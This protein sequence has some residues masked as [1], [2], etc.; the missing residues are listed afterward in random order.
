MIYGL[1]FSITIKAA[2]LLRIFPSKFLGSWERLYGRS[3]EFQSGRSVNGC[4]DPPD[5]PAGSEMREELW[6]RSAQ[7]DPGFQCFSWIEASVSF[8]SL[9]SLN[10]KQFYICVIPDGRIHIPEEKQTLIFLCTAQDSIP[11]PLL[12]HYRQQIWDYWGLNYTWNSTLQCFHSQFS[13]FCFTNTAIDVIIWAR[14][15]DGGVLNPFLSV[16][17]SA[18]VSSP[19]ER[20]SINISIK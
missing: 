15:P 20:N 13:S 3:S 11:S 10:F 16:K 7:Q 4:D 14:L 6:W 1:V 12:Y 19:T 17:F 8:H 2:L 18:K 5:H 9:D